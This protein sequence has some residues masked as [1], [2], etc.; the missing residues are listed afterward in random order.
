[1]CFQNVTSPGLQG[2]SSCWTKP[3]LKDQVSGGKSRCHPGGTEAKVPDL[4]NLLPLL[5]QGCGAEPPCPTR[6]SSTRL[7]AGPTTSSTGW[8][9]KW[10]YC[11]SPTTCL[12]R[13]HHC[14]A[15]GGCVLPGVHT[16]TCPASHLR[17][18]TPLSH[19][20]QLYPVPNQ[21][22]LCLILYGTE[23]ETEETLGEIS[24]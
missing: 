10:S 20:L 24:F 17:Q 13:R 11:V 19:E 3:G 14:L 5:L 7:A 23:L 1:M 12:G 4:P 9:L 18:D 2:D 8:K 22:L 6:L 21:M 16:H 15:A